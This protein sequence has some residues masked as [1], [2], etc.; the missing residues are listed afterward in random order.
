[1]IPFSG[2]VARMGN[3]RLPKRV[4]LEGVEGGKDY[5]GGQEHDLMDSLEHDLSLFKT[6]YRFRQGWNE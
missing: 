6:T 4:M 5:S 1:M 3:E 2:F